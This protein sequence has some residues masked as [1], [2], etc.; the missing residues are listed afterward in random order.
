LGHA[1]GVSFEPGQLLFERFVVLGAVPRAGATNVWAVTD[2]TTQQPCEMELYPPVPLNVPAWAENL[3]RAATFA[4]QLQHPHIL[5]LLDLRVTPQFTAAIWQ[6][7]GPLR[8]IAGEMAMH[9]ERRLPFLTAA[10][11]LEQL[12]GALDFIHA[13]Q[14]AHGALNVA[15]LFVGADGQLRLAHTCVV[16]ALREIVLQCGQPWDAADELPMLSPQRWDGA[17][18]SAADDNYAFGA[19]AYCVLSGAPPFNQGDLAQQAR[20]QPVAPIFLRT[21]PTGAPVQ[22]VPP[23]WQAFINACLAKQPLQRPSLLVP[24]LR[25]AQ[26]QATPPPPPAMATFPTGAVPPP[27]MPAAFHAPPPPVPVAPPVPAP[28]P[29][30]A[31][32]AY[33]A[34]VAPPP[35]APASVVAPPPAT[36]PAPGVTPPPAPIVTPPPA[37]VPVVVAPV[38]PPPP[39]PVRVPVPPAPVAP[40][41][42]PAAPAKVAEE[43]AAAPLP[44]PTPISTPPPAAAPVERA[45]FSAA[46][47][48]PAAPTPPVEADDSAVPV[49]APVAP[50]PAPA[51]EPK[52]KPAAPAKKETPK[53]VEKP[54]AV[55]KPA[56]VEKA[57]STDA[58][59]DPYRRTKS[60]SGKGPLVFGAVALVV[61]A[62]GFGA[63]I[64]N[65]NQTKAKLQEQV[66]AA[67]RQAQSLA[68]ANN[69]SGALTVLKDAQ[70][71][72]PQD[73]EIPAEIARIEAKALNRRFSA[74]LAE[75]KDKGELAQPA[76]AEA[77]IAQTLQT[78][79]ANEGARALR[80]ALES[81]QRRR[82]AAK[83]A[84]EEKRIAEEVR[85]AKLKA[86]ENAAAKAEA[87][88]TR[89]TLEIAQ[90]KLQIMQADSADKA[91]YAQRALDQLLVMAPADPELP[92]L[93]ARV[94]ALTKPKETPPAPKP[95][96][97]PEPAATVEKTTPPP[98]VAPA[99][100]PTPPAPAKR[101][102][103]QLLSRV[104]PDYPPEL[105]RSRTRG[106]VELSFYVETDGTVREV[107]IVS[108]TH[109]AFADAA[110]AA[111]KQFTFKPATQD[112]KPI[113]FRV[114]L[115]IDF[116]P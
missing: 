114:D 106:S 5:R 22:D 21:T 71:L 83:K 86:E 12:A 75:I 35:P 43:I 84:A 72:V 68:E 13:Q 112:G 115:P 42:P 32:P 67:L 59:F 26:A 48:A 14:A 82:D 44:T 57:K 39:E 2:V 107:M 78:D 23:A 62:L 100:A 45:S 56:V 116:N 3:R 34:P 1:T 73:T 99:P 61:I 108:A 111:V 49:P 52:A 15:R 19:V 31:P 92:Q 94:A 104:A 88:T 63:Y 47:P 41:P 8:P 65:E 27:P 33:T 10:P 103:P 50:T 97:K 60:G 30:V 20:A 7:G 24:A 80:L 58:G 89:R 46:T 25:V 4:S 81:V 55:E 79:P 74:Y 64:W 9:P 18:V 77:L 95:E 113:R 17:V 53:P 76:E 96:A 6:T 90:L 54:K 70:K 69:E 29:V 98:T 40:P 37:P 110:T 36:A 87:E 93:S 38:A 16:N 28:A 109:R 66:A 11:W 101:V 51:P 91:P 102:P 105:W 85:L